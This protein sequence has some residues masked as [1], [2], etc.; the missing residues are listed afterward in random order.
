MSCEN[1][2]IV[3]A[4]VQDVIDDGAALFAE[5]LVQGGAAAAT[6]APRARRMRMRL[7]LRLCACVPVLVPLP[8][9]LG[10]AAW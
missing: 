5:V 2:T 1:S 7:C 9:P 10:A 8:L 4:E 3:F 6:T